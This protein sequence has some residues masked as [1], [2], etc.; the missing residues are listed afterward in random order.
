MKLF[1]EIVVTHG[2]LLDLLGLAGLALVAF[3]G[4]RIAGRHWSGSARLIA[5]G[6]IALLAGRLSFLL[7]RVFASPESPYPLSPEAF[8]LWRNVPALLLTAGLGI[9][10]WGFW[11][12]ERVRA[13]R[14][15]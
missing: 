6:A 4:L 3:A 14:E 1:L 11:S 9:L 7:L 15:G 8:A 2:F 12:H 10:V 5:F 13:G